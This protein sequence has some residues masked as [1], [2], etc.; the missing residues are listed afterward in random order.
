MSGH[1]AIVNATAGRCSAK[2]KAPGPGL[3]L[4]GPQSTAMRCVATL[5]LSQRCSEKNQNSKQMRDLPV[6]PVESRGAQVP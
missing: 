5:S 4:L 6:L 1:G 3:Y 2:T